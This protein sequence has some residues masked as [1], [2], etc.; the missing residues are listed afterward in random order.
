MFTGLTKAYKIS[1]LVLGAQS[2]S[3]NGTEAHKFIKALGF[4]AGVYQGL[5]RALMA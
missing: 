3:L 1:N 5:T 2:T 4:L